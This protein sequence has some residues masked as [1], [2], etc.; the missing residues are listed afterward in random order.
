MRD[1]RPGHA[2]RVSRY[3]VE[4]RIRT[5]LSGTG[6]WICG[7]PRAASRATSTRDIEAPRVDGEDAHVYSAGK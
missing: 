3:L 1:P 2:V 4:E 5:A 7:I 6:P